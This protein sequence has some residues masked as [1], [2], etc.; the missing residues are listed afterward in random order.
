MRT[1][2]YTTHHDLTPAESTAPPSPQADLAL[3]QHIHT[4]DSLMGSSA[5]VS[6]TS[7]VSSFASATAPLL[8]NQSHYSHSHLE[9]EGENYSQSH[10][11]DKRERNVKGEEEDT[12]TI[13]SPSRP[14]SRLLS[15][16]QMSLDDSFAQREVHSLSPT[17]LSQDSL[18]D[19][20]E[21]GL[22]MPRPS[23][24]MVAVARSVLEEEVEEEDEYE[25]KEDFE[26]NSEEEEEQDDND[27]DDDEMFE[28][29]FEYESDDDDDIEHELS[30][31]IAESIRSYFSGGSMSEEGRDNIEELFS[32][33]DAF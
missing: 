6:Q 24:A 14:G 27:D 32:S 26:V 31:S 7:M 25:Y 16:V 12:R 21:S 1:S 4:I 11:E 2:T 29:E 15:H 18:N 22:G 19:S 20:L 23:A 5:S 33:D 13:V 8:C 10:F 3:G 30:M 28:E 17:A 9:G